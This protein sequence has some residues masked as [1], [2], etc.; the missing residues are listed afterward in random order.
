MLTKLLPVLKSHNAL[1]A[2]DEINI[3]W[4]RYIDIIQL[5]LNMVFPGQNSYVFTAAAYMDFDDKEHL[6]FL[7]VGN[8]H[9]LDDPL[10]KYSEIYNKMPADKNM[11]YL[12]NQIEATVEDN[13]KILNNT[14]SHILIL[15]L[16]LL[17]QS[18]DYNQ[19]FDIGKKVFIKLFDGI[20]DINDYFKKCTNIE[21]ILEYSSGNISD[22]VLFSEEDDLSLPF[23]ERFTNAIS[24]T[25]FMINIDKSDSFNF[26]VLVFGHIQ[27]AIDVIASCIE[28]KCIPYIRYPVALHYISLLSQGML[29]VEHMK[30]LRYRMSVA[31]IVYQLFDKENLEKVNLETFLNKNQEYDF[32]KK[33][34]DK[35][36]QQG[37]NENNFL[38]HSIRQL[39]IDELQ[40]FYDFLNK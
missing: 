2:L 22:F 21:D 39:V 16:R 40:C 17:T 3:F 14:N 28:Y 18:N 5:Y 31:F 36:E 1:V 24:Q 37:I 26:F 30:I 25:D 33:L 34:F 9:I 32:N 19:L 38:Q 15:P 35:F 13:I 27:Q 8:K 10:S 4:T 7:L 20:E 6:P 23:K 11:V 29:D 12:Y